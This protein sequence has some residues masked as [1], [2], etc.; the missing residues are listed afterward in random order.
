[1]DVRIEKSEDHVE[2]HMA[3]EKQM[4]RPNALAHAS[5]QPSFALRQSSGLFGVHKE[6]PRREMEYPECGVM[7]S[8]SL[9]I[10][11]NVGPPCRICLPQN[12]L[13]V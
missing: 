13:T 5:T 7:S 10:L 2:Q 4:Q 12:G 9:T 11:V 8:R 1:M 3:S 6:S